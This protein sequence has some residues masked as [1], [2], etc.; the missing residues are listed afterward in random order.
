MIILRK[1]IKTGE[2]INEYELRSNEI[3]FMQDGTLYIVTPDELERYECEE[4]EDYEFD[5]APYC[6]EKDEIFIMQ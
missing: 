4:I 3:A 5:D 1:N 2:V 6:L